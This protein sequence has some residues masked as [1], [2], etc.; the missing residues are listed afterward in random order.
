MKAQLIADAIAWHDEDGVRHEE[1][2]RGTEVDLPSKEFDRL[3]ELGAVAK[4]GSA[5]AETSG[6]ET[7]EQLADTFSLAKLKEIAASEGVEDASSFK[8]KSDAASAIV[9]NRNP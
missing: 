1:D 4:A 9:A 6:D 2:G 8:N 7:A 3:S 5:A